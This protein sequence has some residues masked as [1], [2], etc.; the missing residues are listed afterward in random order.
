MRG[1]FGGSLAHADPVAE[2]CVLAA[3][4]D[5]TITVRGTEGQR[6]V[7]ACDFFTA[8][9]ESAL[10]PLEMVTET[11][12]ATLPARTALRKFS[13]RAGAPAVV[14]AGVD[15]DMDMDDGRCVRA[16]IAAGASG[17][18]LVR[19]HEAEALLTGA[20]PDDELLAE[21]SRAVV[22][23]LETAPRAQHVGPLPRALAQGVVR[24]AIDDAIGGPE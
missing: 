14:I 22:S 15:M 10:S 6:D 12:F 13:R 2:W 9:F 19:A 24:E 11:A 8:P 7:A 3:L 4:F 1:T 16:R 20:E 21:V 23:A 18:S 17:S 5:A